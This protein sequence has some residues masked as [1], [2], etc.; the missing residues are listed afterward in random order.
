MRGLFYF[1]AFNG[2]VFL[3]LF[4]FLRA[5]FTDPGRI[6]EGMKAPFQSEYMK[7]E[8]CKEC[9]KRPTWKP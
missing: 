9:Y 3:T 8:D 4:S 2:S 7:M 1:I 6:K 5:A